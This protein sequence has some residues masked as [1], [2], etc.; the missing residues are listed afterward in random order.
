MENQNYER[1]TP[2]AP[3]PKP[4]KRGL[5]R[6]L[7]FIIVAAVIACC[8]IGGAWFY[9]ASSAGGTHTTP[10]SSGQKNVEVIAINGTIEAAGDTYNQSFINSRIETAKNDADNVGIVLRVD[11]P[12]GAVYECDE[13]YL[14]LMDYKE[15]TGRPIYTYCESM[16]ASA[17]Y[18]ISCSS[19]KI[20]ANRNSLVGSIGVI[21]GQFVDAQGLLEKLGV[22]IT[23]VHSGA[24]KLMGSLTEPPTDEQIAI[25]QEVS[26]EAYDQF[27]GIV[28]QGRG[29]DQETV[30]A[31]ADGRVYTAQQGL[32]NGLIDE[33]A[34]SEEFDQAVK[35]A[36]GDDLVF[37]RSTYQQD[38]WTKFMSQLGGLSTAL[39]PASA[40]SDLEQT[41]KALDGLRITRPMYL[42]Q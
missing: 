28:A 1:L 7:P 5:R 9:H 29:L 35:D 18:Y 10:F 24:N 39:R 6:F 34:T 19:D 27:V 36:L 8:A 30:R 22:S 37:N 3:G 13:T 2:D 38:P 16:A 31:L 32:E 23:T 41:L 4:K 17:A 20:Y 11:S 42:Y 40:D 15:T 26:D 21:A 25:M 33:I 14:K 12:G